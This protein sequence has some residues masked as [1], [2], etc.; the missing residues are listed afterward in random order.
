MKS[1]YIE[2]QF[3]ITIEY[4]Q[5]LSRLLDIV[6]KSIVIYILFLRVLVIMSIITLWHTKR[7]YS[8]HVTFDGHYDTFKSVINPLTLLRWWLILRQKIIVFI[9]NFL[10]LIF[11]VRP[12]ILS[13]CIHYYLKSTAVSALF[14][15]FLVK[16][17][18]TKNNC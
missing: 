16:P 17:Q 5:I 14:N 13:R 2:F 7:S 10:D 15:L 18:T 6:F 3:L 9:S 12:N 1:S 11:R 4:I 8:V